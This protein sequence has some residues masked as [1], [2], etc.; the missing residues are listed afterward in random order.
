MAQ[1]EIRLTTADFDPQV[2]GLLDQYVHGLLDRRGFL[3]RAGRLLA[4]N[5][6]AAAA[7]LGIPCP[8]YALGQRVAPDDARLRI[9]SMFA[10]RDERVDATGPD[11]EAALKQAGVRYEAYK[12]PGPLHGFNNDTTPRYHAQAAQLA[13]DRT[14]AFFGRTLR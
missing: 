5:G 9:E 6:T 11:Y 12:Y 7:L 14:L 10:E 3:K 1:N 4:G 2:L 8:H 13:W